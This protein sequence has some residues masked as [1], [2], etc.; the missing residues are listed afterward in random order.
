VLWLAGEV[1]HGRQVLVV[2]PELGYCA[3]L[4]NVQN[5]LFNLGDKMPSPRHT[6]FKRRNCQLQKVF[7]L[8]LFPTAQQALVDSKKKNS[9][10]DVASRLSTAWWRSHSSWRPRPP[11]W[12]RNRCSWFHRCCLAKCAAVGS[13][14]RAATSQSEEKKCARTGI[15][16]QSKP[17]SSFQHGSPYYVP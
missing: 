17:R 5:Q 6:I 11:R 4:P 16:F 7:A 12:V 15:T 14:L 13:C 9:P 1:R 10:S 2:H 3:T 8:A